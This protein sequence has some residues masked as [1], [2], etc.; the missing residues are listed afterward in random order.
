[1]NCES[2]RGSRQRD[3]SFREDDPCP[4]A[5]PQAAAPFVQQG[6]H[7]GGARRGLRRAAAR[8]AGAAG[9]EPDVRRPPT[10]RCGRCSLTR[11]AARSLSPP[12]PRGRRGHSC[13][14]G[15]RR[16]RS[17]ARCRSGARCLSQWP[18]SVMRC[19]IHPGISCT[20]IRPT[21]RSGSSGG[22]WLSRCRSTTR[23]ASTRHN[24][25]IWPLSPAGARGVRKQRHLGREGKCSVLLDSVQS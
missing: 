19:G 14:P 1:M 3:A 5:G 8:W 9:V 24:Q 6:C 25:S 21:M 17:S 20:A 16:R 2:D 18:G 13:R 7:Q 22:R 10:A 23:C 4:R 15:S 11:H 12:G